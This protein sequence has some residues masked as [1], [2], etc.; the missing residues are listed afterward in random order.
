MFFYSS[1]ILSYTPNID[2]P[3]H[4]TG[5]SNLQADGHV[6][7]SISIGAHATTTHHSSTPTPSSTPSS[8]ND[9]SD[10]LFPVKPIDNLF[11]STAD[12]VDGHVSLSDDTF[13]PTN[14]IK[15]LTHNYLE[16]QGKHAMQAHY[17]KGSWNFQQEPRGGISFYAPGPANVDLTTAKE[18]TLAYSVFFPDGY[19]FVKGGKLPGFCT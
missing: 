18:A 2:P 5:A 1:E 6:D 8:S 3:S 14:E 15:E 9:L 17:P 4:T 12:G 11:W 10:I 19:D 13:R 16:Y 7:I